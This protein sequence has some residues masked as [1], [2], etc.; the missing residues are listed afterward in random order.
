MNSDKIFYGALER[1]TKYKINF[2]FLDYPSYDGVGFEIVGI[3]I[4]SI[5]TEEEVL[6]DNVLL[7]RTKHGF[8]VPV[9]DLSPLEIAYLYF[10]NDKSITK[11]HITHRLFLDTV[12]S[13]LGD[14]TVDKESLVPYSE[15]KKNVSILG[16]Q[17][18]MKMN[19][20]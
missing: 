15:T 2:I 4:G 7:I 3:E 18:V 11:G 1:C 19:K 8:Y 6:N 13:K 14:I 16:T 12:P 5:E 9:G 17:K 10:E 20:K